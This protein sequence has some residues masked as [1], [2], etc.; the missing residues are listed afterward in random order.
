[1][2]QCTGL[3]IVAPINRAVDDKAAKTLLGDSFKRQLK[4]DGGFSNV[5]FICSKTDDISITEA[6]DT[7]EL[8]DEVEGLY[9][10][11]RQCQREIEDVKEKIEDL[12]EAKEV[13]KLAQSEAAKDIDVW[14]K[15]QERLHNGKTVYAPIPKSN[16]RKKTQSKSEDARKRR[17]KDRDDSEDDFIAS[18]EEDD[19]STES[20]ESDDEGIQAPRKPL[21]E[22]EIKSK[23]QDLRESKKTARRE[24]LE[25]SHK[26]E[27]LRPTS[28]EL[29]DKIASIK[30]EISRICIAGRND[31]SKRAIQQD[32]AAGIKE[33]DQE[34]AAEEDEE[35]FNPD[36]ELR[37]YDEVARSLPVFCVSSRAFQ[38]MCGRLKKDDSVP[39]FT[40]PEET[41]MPQLQAHCTKLTE[42]G[43]V[44]TARS[45]LLSLCQQLMTF[46]LWA[47]NDGTG[48][49]MTDDDKRKQVRYLEKRL[50]ELERG[51]EESVRSCLNV[52]KKEMNDQIFNR[53]PDLINEAIE[54]A[55]DTA[56]KWGAHKSD[57]GLGTFAHPF[58]RTPGTVHNF[59]YAD[60]CSQYGRPTKR[61]FVETAYINHAQPA[62]GTSTPI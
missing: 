48:L 21:T 49:K 4:Y 8:E 62:S 31:Y 40:T 33:L 55:P 51:L 1:M 20:D 60:L 54:A 35:N 2:K 6:I 16:K 47:S 5:T 59:A 15:L 41:G 38:Q 7:L 45:F 17:Q 29:K 18:D 34:N 61:S 46:S 26:I 44:Q 28:R 42:A 53:Y 39:G 27:E 10:Q 3:W 50:S 43:R 56:Q 57:G 14:A 36:E 30:A 23:I 19:S 32:F 52:M 9:D 37:D 24:G 58:S 25:I 22:E 11:Q 13:Y 12:K